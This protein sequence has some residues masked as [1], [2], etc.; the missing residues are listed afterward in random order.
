M[1]TFAS[2]TLR[3]LARRYYQEGS[4]YQIFRDSAVVIEDDLN[5]RLRAAQ[6]G[7]L[8]TIKEYL[9]A[10]FALY[11]KSPVSTIFF[12]DFEVSPVQEGDYRYVEVFY[13][14]EFQGRYRPTPDVPYPTR[15]KKATVR[16][17]REEG[18]WKVLITD[19]SSATPEEVSQPVSSE[20]T[21]RQ[22][23]AQETPTPEEPAAEAL[24][25][26]STAMISTEA[27]PIDTLSAPPSEEAPT[28]P[29][30]EVVFAQVKS[31]YR[32]GKTYDIT[33]NIDSLTGSESL[34]LYRNDTLQQILPIT[35]NNAL[36]WTVPEELPLG[37]DYQFRFAGFASDTT[38]SS[39]PFRVVR[40]RPWALYAGATAGAAVILYLLLDGG[41]DEVSPAGDNLLP[42]PPNPE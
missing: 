22:E 6:E 7:D 38:L 26:D 19:I 25:A 35:G 41:S 28:Q 3:G 39:T 20:V 12:D 31:R 18:I 34:D 9:K 24:P 36:T 23:I 11:E 15:V 30:A 1:S 16:A 2:T 33:L 27:T 37:S 29:T 5:P 8:R 42:E 10:F 40:K 13:D 32:R 4:N 14:S 21:P 17:V